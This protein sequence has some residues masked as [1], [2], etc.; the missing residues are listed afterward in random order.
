MVICAQYN[1]MPCRTHGMQK[2]IYE[3]YNH[4]S[5]AAFSSIYKLFAC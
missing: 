2:D 4:W 3:T 5:I 1:R